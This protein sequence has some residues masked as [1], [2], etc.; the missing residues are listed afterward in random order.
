M[1]TKLIFLCNIASS[2]KIGNCDL[3]KDFLQMGQHVVDDNIVSVVVLSVN[4]KE[5]LS[6]L[7]TYVLIYHF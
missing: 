4:D 7:T 3:D 2:Q 5:A 1:E 6:S